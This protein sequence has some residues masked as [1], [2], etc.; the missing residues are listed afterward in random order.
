MADKPR[1]LGINEFVDKLCTELLSAPLKS[2]YEDEA[3]MRAD[4]VEV[5]RVFTRAR[6]TPLKLSFNIWQGGDERLRAVSICGVDFRPDMAI[7]VG[8]LPIVAFDL[9]LVKAGEDPR[10]KLSS[11]LGKALIC[12]QY[13]PTVIIFILGVGEAEAYKH[14]LDWEFKAELWAKHKIKLVIRE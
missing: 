3:S 9:K 6:L 13:Y 5:I 10:E 7:E 4:V 11:A 12:C 14:W 8:E 1:Y 2:Y